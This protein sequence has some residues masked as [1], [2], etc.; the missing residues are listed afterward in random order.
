MPGVLPS[1]FR[2]FFKRRFPSDNVRIVDS[3]SDE[4]VPAGRLHIIVSRY[5]NERQQTITVET[6]VLMQIL[7][8]RET[9]HRVTRRIEMRLEALE[10]GG[11]EGQGDARAES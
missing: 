2:A 10:L 5:S 6:P 3:T 1:H 11:P 8:G 4:S 9:W 7:D